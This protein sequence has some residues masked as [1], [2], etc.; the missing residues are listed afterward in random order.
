MTKLEMLK[1]PVMMITV[2]VGLVLAEWLLDIDVSRITK[3]GPQGI[4]LVQETREHTSAAVSEVE[5]KLKELTARMEALEKKTDTSEFSLTRKD[6]LLLRAEFD[7]VSDAV[8]QLSMSQSKS[9]RTVL[10]GRQGYI[11]IGIY[12]STDGEWKR[13]ILG[14]QDSRQPVT[15]APDQLL[16]GG[17]YLVDTNMVLR[18][19]LPP[20]DEQYFRSR[21][22]MGV[23]PRGTLVALL[24][25]PVGINRGFAVEFWAPVEVSE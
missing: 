24:D 19:G 16:V 14:R 15:S 21:K 8:S 17:R 22:N 9:T 6:T 18:D 20:N 23:I 5:T 4:E 12:N 2:I 10:V 7:E 11:F 13:A 1:Y 25:Q 3:I